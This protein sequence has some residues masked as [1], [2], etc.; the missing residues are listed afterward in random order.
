MRAAAGVSSD[1]ILCGW[2]GSKH[3]PKKFCWSYTPWLRFDYT[4]AFLRWQEEDR[5]DRL[6]LL[7]NHL[8][9]SKTI[10]S[11]SIFHAHS[12]PKVLKWLLTQYFRKRKKK[13]ETFPN[14]KGTIHMK[15][16]LGKACV[17]NA[18]NCYSIYSFS[19]CYQIK[20][21]FQWIFQHYFKKV[22]IHLK[23]KFPT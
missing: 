11:E 5:H 23:L 6:T 10:Y 8:S 13:R 7:T 9:N 15:R 18:I 21:V 2:Q 19:Y 3:Q 1:I 17:E 4:A 12:K 14:Q 22:N 16:L 20:K